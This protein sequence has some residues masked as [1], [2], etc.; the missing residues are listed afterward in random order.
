MLQLD[1]KILNIIKKFNRYE[2]KN[3]ILY[4]SFQKSL[5]TE[6]M[7]P[8]HTGCLALTEMNESHGSS[9]LP[10][11]PPSFSVLLFSKSPEVVTSFLVQYRF[12]DFYEGI[13][14]THI[15]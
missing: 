11:F 14:V 5:L 7:L 8:F 12:K 4:P 10:S 1:S 13:I 15:S 6:S 2:N 9:F 3:S